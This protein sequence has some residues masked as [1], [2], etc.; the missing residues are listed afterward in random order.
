MEQMKLDYGTIKGRINGLWKMNTEITA[1]D[2]F[3]VA[4]P[5]L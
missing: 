2:L 5:S 4:Y 3:V 1:N